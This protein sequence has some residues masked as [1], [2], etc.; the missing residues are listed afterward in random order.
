MACSL[1]VTFREESLKELLFLIYISYVRKNESI[2]IQL[3][4]SSNMKNK[5]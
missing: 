1:K 2:I 5:K 3:L 4:I